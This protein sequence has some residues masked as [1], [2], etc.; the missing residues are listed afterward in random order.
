M[1]IEVVEIELVKANKDNPRFIKDE[2][3]EKLVE[4]IRA[5]PEMLNI[6]P[7]VVNEDMVTLGGNMRLKACKAAGLKVVPIIRVNNL[8]ED[9]QREFIIK[10]NIGYGQWDWD[11]LANEWDS[12]KLVEWGLDVWVE[13]SEEDVEGEG[14]GEGA[15]K[16]VFLEMGEG[17]YK[18]MLEML[19]FWKL[20][21]VYVGGKILSYLRSER[22]KI[23]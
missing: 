2:N 15:V 7:I 23:N 13:A 6:R 22:G 16:K 9:Q 11:I 1:K 14:K 3:F 20:R 17:D 12:D 18:E 21:G 10:D 8:S 4:S 5:F 19:N